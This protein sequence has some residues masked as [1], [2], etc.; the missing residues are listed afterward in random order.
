M[1]DE[2]S[3][4]KELKEKLFYKKRTFFETA[5]KDGMAAALEYA[6]GY[7]EYLDNAKTERDAVD[8]SVKMLDEAGF[9]P[10]DFGDKL[11][12]GGRYYY[13]N[14]GKSLY[15]FTLGEEC[16]SS[17]IR[18]TAAHIDSPRIDLKQHTLYEEKGIGYFKTH[19]YGGVRKYQWTVVPLALHGVVVKENGET[20][21]INV[22]DEDGDPVFC[23][24]DLLPHLAAEQ[25]GKPLGQAFS[26][27]GMNVIVGSAPYIDEDEDK[28]DDAVK[29]NIINTLYEK[30][31]I[32]E[33][34]LMSAELCFVP[35][36]KARDV[37]FDRW[38]IGAYGHDDIVCAYPALTALMDAKDSAHSLM[39]ILADKEE[40]GSEGVSG[41]Q[42][43]V[44][45]DLVN[46]ISAAYGADPA[47]V[48][49]NSMCLSAD[50]CASYDPNY[51][52]V[53]ELSNSAI[54]GAGVCMAKY[55]GARGKSATNDASAELVGKVRRM[56]D[57]EGVVWQTA[58][59]G[60]VD[61][62]GGGTVAKY[63]AKTNVETVDV[64]VPVLSMHAPFELISKADLYSAY[65]AF[66]AFCK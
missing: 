15:V 16:V 36:G 58:E 27:E 24:T 53:Y 11:E 39:C 33:S 50:V 38:L 7:T 46:A 25:N 63:I 21:N 13:N 49:A 12:K 61:A 26:G 44:F 31:G 52:E 5:G 40:I 29:L 23:I 6:K 17:G 4:S 42:C 37:G 54:T 32:T 43:D 18:I 30:Y 62:G 2:K 14:R 65:T 55:T 1:A 3:K 64:G 59:L 9:K 47:K 45:L 48:R 22:G 8:Y 51:K 28:L 56:F 19:Y 20:V 66:A 10:F 60:K 41:M 34:D 35:A 57:G